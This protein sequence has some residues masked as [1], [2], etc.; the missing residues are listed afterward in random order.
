MERKKIKNVT[1]QRP[2]IMVYQDFLESDLLDDCQ[3]KL[4]YIYLKKFTNDDSQCF[5]SIKKL[6]QLTKIGTTKLK[7]TL[8]KL[9]EKGVIAIENR[10]KENGGKSSNL[11]TLYDYAEIWNAGNSKE[12]IETISETISETKMIEALKARGYIV[13]KEKGLVSE[14]TKEQ[15]QDT[16]SNDSSD[17]DTTLNHSECQEKYTLDQLKNLFDYEAMVFDRPDCK[18]E[19]DSIMNILH[20]TL[21]TTKKTIRVQGENKSAKTV[22]AKLLKLNH[23]DILYAIDRFGEQ[24]NRIKNTKSY[25]LTLL[26]TAKEQYSLDVQNQVK[27]DSHNQAVKQAESYDEIAEALSDLWKK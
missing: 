26:Y 4:V 7:Q 22:V 18:E 12:D 27:H 5:P 25:M 21:N 17:N 6:S 14:P 23:T 24:N 13:K 8:G 19:I 3:Q 2:Y 15:K 11:Y 1:D 20:D 16:N 9:E 10:K